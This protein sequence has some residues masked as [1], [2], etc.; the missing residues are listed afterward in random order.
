[1]AHGVLPPFSSFLYSRDLA[2]KLLECG[3]PEADLVLLGS[4]FNELRIPCEM[5]ESSYL[6]LNQVKRVLEDSGLDKTRFEE[7]D[8]SVEG[9][10]FYILLIAYVLGIDGVEVLLS[11][12][13]PSVF[14]GGTAWKT[15][16]GGSLDQ[17]ILSVEDKV[18]ALIK[19][20]V[21]DMS[22]HKPVLQD[23]EVLESFI[24]MY[25]R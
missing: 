4:A 6:L 3:K 11:L 24:D 10:R 12:I 15:M 21:R 2:C 14:E 13:V 23:L 25:S 17:R 16:I 5:A 20:S 18:G 7:L 8:S 1:M 19:V 22:L 9:R